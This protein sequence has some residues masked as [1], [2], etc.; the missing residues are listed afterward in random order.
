MCFHV[1]SLRFGLF[2]WSGETLMECGADVN[3]GESRD[4]RSR[5]REESVGL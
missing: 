3:L 5:W 2:V 4:Q 1:N